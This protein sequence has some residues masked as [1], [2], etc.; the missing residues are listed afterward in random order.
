M[1]TDRSHGVGMK[2]LFVFHLHFSV[3]KEGNDMGEEYRAAE[4]SSYSTNINPTLG[5]R[6]SLQHGLSR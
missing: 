4:S 2:Q 1:H 3:E 6:K 5:W